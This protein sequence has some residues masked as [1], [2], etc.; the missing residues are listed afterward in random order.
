MRSTE[1][2]SVVV[3]LSLAL[4]SILSIAALSTEAWTTPPTP[5]YVMGLDFQGFPG[6]NKTVPVVITLR[7]NYGDKSAAVDLYLLNLSA[8]LSDPYT[9]Y[10]EVVWRRIAQFTDLPSTDKMVMNMTLEEPGVY[11]IG[12]L[13]EFGKFGG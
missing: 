13:K 4:L 1:K 12:V 5:P 7:S 11:A 9:A 3:G 8:N 6:L 10:K 2:L